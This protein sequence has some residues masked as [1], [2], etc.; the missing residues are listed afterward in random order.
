MAAALAAADAGIVSAPAQV[1]VPP[2]PPRLPPRMP[3]AGPPPPP[4][5]MPP[6]IPGGDG[7]GHA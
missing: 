7:N 4:P 2:M 1:S 3:A 6:A 5:P